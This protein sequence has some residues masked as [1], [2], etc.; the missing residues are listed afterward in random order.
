MLL[1]SKIMAEFGLYEQKLKLVEGG[2]RNHP[3]D[4]GGAT[5]RGITLSTFREYYG[6]GKTLKDLHNMTEEQWQAIMKGGYWDKVKADEILN[7]S[8]AEIIADWCIN[9]GQ[10]GIR[11]TQEVLGVKPDG[12]VGPKTLAAIN[13]ADPRDLHERILQARHQFYRNIVK[14]NPSQEEFF[15][16]WMNRLDQFKYE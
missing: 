6:E 4:L 15:D 14:K 3:A 2:F 16:G 11:K 10:T 9:S 13:S 7:Q 5:M 12:I 1:N 8:V